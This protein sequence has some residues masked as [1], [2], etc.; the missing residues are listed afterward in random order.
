MEKIRFFVFGFMFLSL[1]LNGK[2]YILVKNGNPNC[3]I[4]ISE[5][6]KKSAQLAAYEL[7]Y[8]IRQITGAEVPIVKDNEEVKG[9]KI[10]VGESKYTEELKLGK[11]LKTQ[12]Y[13][14]KFLPDSIVLLGKDKD[15]YGEVKYGV[16]DGWK[17]FP[18]FYDEQ[19]TLYATYDFL[20]R[21]CGVRWFNPTDWGTI[22]PEK[23]TLI[24]KGEDIRRKPFFL[25]R[26]VWP[27][28]YNFDQYDWTTTGLWKGTYFNPKNPDPDYIEYMKI[29]YE[30]LR[31]KYPKE[32]EFIEAK[33]TQVKLFLHRMRV[34][35]ER[36]LCNHSLYGYYERFWGENATEGKR[37]EF[38]AKGYEGKPPQLCYTNPELIKQVAQDA[39]DYYDGKKTARDLKIFWNPQLPNPFPVEPMDNAS[40]CKCENCQKLI[41]KKW[42]NSPYYSTGLHSNYFFYFVNEVA[43]ELRKTHP[44]KYIITLAYSTHA[45][46]PDFEIEPNVYIEF[47]FASNRGPKKTGNYENEIN[48]LTEWRKRIKDRPIFLWL[49]YTFP[50]EFADGGNYWC[51]PGSFAH[52]IDEQFKLFKE[53]KIGGIAHCGYGQEIEAYI[54]YKLM[55]DPSLDVDKLLDEYFKLLYGKGWKEMKEF[56]LL[57]ERRFLD[58]NNYPDKKYSTNMETFW[59]YLGNDE[60]MGK[61]SNYLEKAKE[62]EDR[63]EYRK[64]IEMFEKAIWSYMKNGKNEYNKIRKTEIPEIKVPYV[65]KADGQ[66]EKV[67]WEK[68]IILS[69][70]YN[71]GS[72]DK[73]KGRYEVRILHDGD[74]LYLEL[75]DFCDTKKLVSSP[76]IF[77]YDDWEIFVSKQRGVPYRQYAVG[78]TGLFVS[79][80]HGE[81]NFANNVPI[82]IKGVKIYSDTKSPDKWI[83]KIALPLKEILKDGIKPGDTFYLNI[84]R[85]ISPEISGKT[86]DIDCLVPY[87]TVH[88]LGRLAEV[89]LEKEEEK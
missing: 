10:L 67:E 37:E 84:V 85:V 46:P 57:C 50:K 77:P 4:V 89:K 35:G 18:D 28:M 47:C 76:T 82:E 72:K 74:Y 24:V 48:A 13:I 32:N 9:L 11:D 64:R 71:K 29:A 60:V 15:D 21:Y 81:M 45:W 20:E 1:F 66:L 80:S 86:L 61:L 75:I 63:E 49:Y 8:H 23:K 36:Y 16:P 59:G 25:M 83:T 34:G 56:Y 68:G 78:P 51:F 33:R 38:F 19:G 52:Q 7:Q 22:Y 2:E 70:W 43:K 14:I 62:K 40:Y 65:K 88:Q 39:R 54:T 31:E 6:P 17:T 73:S 58:I 3:S 5:K 87:T 41:N 12:E 27:S 53:Y 79:L 26:D 42:E 44:D 55:D 30:K 69:Q